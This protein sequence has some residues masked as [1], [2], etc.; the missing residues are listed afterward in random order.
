MHL[1]L[2]PFLARVVLV[3][4]RKFAVVALVQRLVLEHR[5]FRLPQLGKHEIERAV[6]AL[7]P[8][9]ERHVERDAL[10]LELAAG[11]FCFLDALFGEVDIL[12]ACE[13]I[14]QIPVALA[15]PDK[16]E[17]AFFVGHHCLYGCFLL[18]FL[19]ALRQT[20]ATT[21]NTPASTNPSTVRSTL[22]DRASAGTIKR[23]KTTAKTQMTARIAIPPAPHF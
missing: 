3:Q 1:L 15:V 20:T 7:E 6:G 19:A 17:D 18:I 21:K 10:R 5:N 4:P 12:P 2:A 13:Q 23:A 8:R 22:K 11:G 16:H 9:G 14:F